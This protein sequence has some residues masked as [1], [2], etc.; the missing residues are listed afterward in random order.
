MW[1][2]GATHNPVPRR[3]WQYPG[4][5]RAS[6]AGAARAVVQRQYYVSTGYNAEQAIA[7]FLP[8]KSGT[9]V[10]YTNCTF[11][12]RVAGFGGPA[13]RSIGRRMMS[14]KLEQIFAAVRT[15]VSELR[16]GQ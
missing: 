4:W 11:T 10:V 2:S 1:R 13:K 3:S 16:L 8:V 12:D 9:I 15:Q 5:S 6:S 14:T 7:E